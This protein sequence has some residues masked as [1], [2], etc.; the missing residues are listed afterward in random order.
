RA[1][2]KAEKERKAYNK[3]LRSLKKKGKSTADLV[4]PGTEKATDGTTTVPLPDAKKYEPT[5]AELKAKAKAEGEDVGLLGHQPVYDEAVLWLA[6]TYIERENWTSADFQFRRLEADDELPPKV[7]E[8]LPVAR[9]YYHIVRE[10]YPQVIPFLDQAI[11]RAGKRADKARYSYI[12]AQI[13]DM[14][15]NAG[16][17]AEYYQK[18]LDFSNQ[19]D[20]EFNTQLSIIR[21]SVKNNTMTIADAQQSLGKMLKDEKNL[22]YKGRIYFVLANLSLEQNDVRGAIAHLENSVLNTGQDNFQEIESQYLLATLYLKE[23]MYVEAEDAFKA[24]SSVMDQKDPRYKY[25]KKM[26]DNLRDIA[27]NLETIELQDSLITLSYKTDDELKVIARELKKAKQK[28]DEEAAANSKYA[29]ANDPKMLN[30]SGAPPVSPGQGPS[31]KQVSDNAPVSVFW[32]FDQRNLKKTK[33]EFDRTW[34]DVPLTDYWRVSSK[35][36]QFTNTADE[37][38]QS[39]DGE[40]GVYE[41]EIENYFRDVPKDDSARAI[42]H[43]TIRKSMLL[44]G[45]L[46]R[47]RIEDFESSIKILE[48]VLE[49][50]PDA[51]EKLETYYQLYLSSLSAGDHAR[52]EKYK[53]LIIQNYPNSRFA[54]VLSDPNF[55]ASQRSE[56][57]RL[58]DYYNETYTYFEA[59]NHVV[60]LERI[61]DVEN[62]FGSNNSL[63]AKFELLRAMS[64]GSQIG[65]DAYI[66]ALKNIVAKYPNSP[67][68]TKARDMLLL[69]GE[70]NQTKSYGETG[71]SDA[72]FT[73]EDNALHFVI[74][75]VSNQDELSVQDT[76]I[77]LA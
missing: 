42:S 41:S 62:Q 72:K 49:K 56:H 50:Y 68:E 53:N 47:D 12:I 59:G 10:N 70:G 71:L 66:D 11:E 2:K 44:L 74:V 67:E 7:Y 77:A 3:K 76:K 30:K 29:G 45:Q 17:A 52:S 32:A 58:M 4:R 51:P 25:V 6:K 27:T 16:K 73:K 46:Y 75:Y 23:L 55:A 33:R 65:K 20:L 36:S 60:V 5:A 15:G 31:G 37:V 63:M 61:R 35:A 69:L 48:D 40:I 1:R 43:N 21:S 18:S 13:Y 26:A 22:N 19:Y 34:G 57:E 14:Q 28:A 38:S 8:E 24:A 9:A 54:K 64:M 39:G